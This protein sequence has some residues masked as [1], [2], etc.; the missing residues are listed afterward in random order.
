MP[1]QPARLKDSSASIITASCVQPAVLRRGLQHRVLA[2]DL[3][4]V[5]RHLELVLHPAHDVEVGH[6]G[7]DHHHVGALGDVERHFAEGFVAVGRIHLVGVF[8]ALAQVAGRA[9]GVAE[10]AVEGGGVLRRV[11][12]DAGVDQLLAVQRGADAADAAVH[13]VR[14]ATTSAPAWAWHSAC[15]ASASR[16]SSFIT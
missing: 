14:G 7:L 5:G 2:A 3:I 1:S 16:V 6:A 11:G 10:G 9:H 15:F 12:Q 4:G 8:V 13:H